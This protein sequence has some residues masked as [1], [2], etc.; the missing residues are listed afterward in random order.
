MTPAGIR[1][2][3]CADVAD[4]PDVGHVCVSLR[5]HRATVRVRAN[6]DRCVDLIDPCTNHF[7]IVI[8]AGVRAG[9]RNAIIH[10]PNIGEESPSATAHVIGC[11][12]STSTWIAAGSSSMISGVNG[13]TRFRR[14]P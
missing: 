9:L 12:A 3:A 14:A 6:G 4:V 8:E 2:A 11:G 13:P 5:H 1:L 10:W 7:D